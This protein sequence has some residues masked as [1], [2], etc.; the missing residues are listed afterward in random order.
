MSDSTQAVFSVP[1]FLRREA[2]NEQHAP[3]KREQFLRC[4]E[5]VDEQLEFRRLNFLNPVIVPSANAP[6]A[7]PMTPSERTRDATAL[8]DRTLLDA[9]T[10]LRLNS[11]GS[12]CYRL[13]QRVTDFALRL[14]GESAARR[15]PQPTG[16]VPR[17]SGFD[18]S[19]GWT[20]DPKWLAEVADGVGYVQDDRP[21]ME[22]VEEVVKIVAAL[23][24]S[25][26]AVPPAISEPEYAARLSRQIFPSTTPAAT[27]AVSKE[28][29]PTR[30]E[31]WKCVENIEGN[32]WRFN[33][34]PDS[35]DAEAAYGEAK[36]D[37]NAMLDRLYAALGRAPSPSEPRKLT[38]DAFEA[39]VHL[40]ASLSHDPACKSREFGEDC[41]CGRDD[42]LTR[43]EGHI[44]SRE[45][46]PSEGA[47]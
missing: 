25:A 44:A 27:P 43:I 10:Y 17:A 21:S 26:P 20:Y 18:A 47:K 37:F 23:S 30:E 40:R 3:W 6:P 33:E 35:D 4:A 19:N 1:E 9:Q 8:E 5:F 12:D 34:H 22:Q 41:D 7:A 29:L 42:L 2:T 24:R 38:G 11:D 45:R 28:G 13:L 39:M 15:A 36:Q 14:A 32:G 31:V 46:E 16:D